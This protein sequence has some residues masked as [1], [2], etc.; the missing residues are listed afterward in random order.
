MTTSA[1]D[2][3]STGVMEDDPEGDTTRPLPPDET[4]VDSAAKDFLGLSAS[5]SNDP[6]LQ[7]VR[8]HASRLRYHTKQMEALVGYLVF[9]SSDRRARSSRAARRRDR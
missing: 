3:Q 4:R 1:V 6:F 7:R 2:P 5:S 9:G 8:H